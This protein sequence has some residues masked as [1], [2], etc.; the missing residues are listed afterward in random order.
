MGGQHIAPDKNLKKTNMDTN[1]R[2]Q[3]KKTGLPGD[4]LYKIT[5]GIFITPMQGKL[6]LKKPNGATQA[7]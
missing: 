4:P 1:A 5:I 3:C 6:H 2:T 7:E